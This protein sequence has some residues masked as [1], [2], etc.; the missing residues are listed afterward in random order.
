MRVDVP[1]LVRELD[2]PVKR[3]GRELWAPCPYA[4]HENDSNPSWSIVDGGERNGY[5]HCFGCDA[6]GGAVD[7]VM[8]V[9]GLSSYAAA[10]AWLREKGLVLDEADLLAVELVIKRP[11]ERSVKS[12]GSLIKPLG[13]V[14]D[15]D[16]WPRLA[17]Q[18]AK[19]R[20]LT[21]QQILRWK[22]ECAIDGDLAGR[23]WIPVV[24]GQNHCLDWTARTWCDDELRYKCRAGGGLPGA[25]F[26]EAYW[27]A[28]EDRKN[29]E[30]VVC[31]G[32]FDAMA[33]ERAGAK[34]VAGL[35]GVARYDRWVAMKIATWGS[36]LIA[37]DPDSAGD[38]VADLIAMLG[39]MS[40][41][42]NLRRVELPS[43]IDCDKLWSIDPVELSR[44]LGIYDGY[45][46]ATRNG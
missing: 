28:I 1:G 21:S 22:I 27:P 40:S 3:Q 15:I 23:L 41:V 20:G 14:A 33:C 4:G 42:R 45:A 12:D 17:V 11:F 5:H 39:R 32:A 6:S 10:A 31:E 30:L 8:E 2:I 44:K 36:I 19:K 29:A 37:V 24:D 38:R 35:G 16:R 13:L 26:G 43:G 9:I 46:V 18:Y 34:Y 25:I 7:L